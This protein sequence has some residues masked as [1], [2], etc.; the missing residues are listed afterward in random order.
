[1]FLDSTLPVRDRCETGPDVADHHAR[2]TASSR[3]EHLLWA[4]AA[5]KSRSLWALDGGP[6][7][8]MDSPGGPRVAAVD[9]RGRDFSGI[10][11]RRA[12]NL[13]WDRKQNVAASEF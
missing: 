4:M 2:H 13:L 7:P 1:M 9:A 12:E 6:L 11:A 8:I 5:S 3:G 10:A